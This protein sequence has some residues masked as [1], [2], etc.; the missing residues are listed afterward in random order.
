VTL[1]L[2]NAFSAGTPHRLLQPDDVAFMLH[3][4]TLLFQSEVIQGTDRFVTDEI[5]PRFAVSFAYQML[6]FPT[7]VERTAQHIKFIFV[8]A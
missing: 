4:E 7:V 5:P 8:S 3:P 1:R 6:K 2:I